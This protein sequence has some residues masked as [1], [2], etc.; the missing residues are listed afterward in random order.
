MENYRLHIDRFTPQTLPMGRLAEYMSDLAAILGHKEY[1]HFDKLQSGSAVLVSH[2]DDEVIP[3]V[4]ERVTAVRHKTAPGDAM[5]AFY[6][7]NKRLKAD[8]AVGRLDRGTAQIIEFP[9]R[10]TPTPVQYGPI[11]KVG[12]VCGVLIKIGGKDDTVPVVLQD[13]KYTWRCNASRKMARELA[14]HLFGGVIR[15][16]GSGG[17][18]RD[19]EGVWSLN[20]FNITDFEVLDNRDLRDVIQELREVPGNRWRDSDDPLEELR[21]IRHGRSEAD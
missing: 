4:F 18:I 10:K 16:Y 14:H 20:R 5:R 17:W 2:V 15:V 12:S 3:K 7:L 13:S 6:E 21:R 11:T 1:V 19:G 9:G 8:N